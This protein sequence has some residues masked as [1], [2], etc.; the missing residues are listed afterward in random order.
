MESIKK[1]VQKDVLKRDGN[2]NV[3]RDQN[4]VDAEVKKEQQQELKNIRKQ[5]ASE[6]DSINDIDEGI[7][8]SWDVHGLLN[9]EP[10]L[11]AEV[12]D[13]MKRG[14]GVCP[15]LLERNLSNGYQKFSL[16]KFYRAHHHGMEAFIAG[17]VRCACREVPQTP[18]VELDNT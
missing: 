1:G 6:S 10:A 17:K 11:R 2:A 16:Q 3:K 4:A 13:M 5:L 8:N 9:F 7:K 15:T 12:E 14:N 18:Q